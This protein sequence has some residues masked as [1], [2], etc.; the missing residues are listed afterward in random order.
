MRPVIVGERRDRDD[1]VPVH[2]S[3]KHVTVVPQF[4]RASSFINQA[5]RAICCP[6]PSWPRWP[7]C[8]V[9]AR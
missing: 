3:T 8:C 7:C 4:A 2:V 9:Q 6:Q 5:E 1:Q